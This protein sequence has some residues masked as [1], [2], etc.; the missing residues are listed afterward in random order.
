MFDWLIWR[1]A[2]N[3][4]RAAQ[5]NEIDR[6]REY[7]AKGADVNAKD[8]IGVTPLFYTANDGSVEAARLLLK[9]GADILHTVP[10]GGTV[11]HSALLK[12]HEDL[13]LFFIDQGANVNQATVAGV[14]PL[15]MAAQSGL[16][17]V[18]ARLL[19]RSS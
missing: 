7:I 4:H 15:H 3:L 16:R 14:T 8:R 11:L 12:E 2:G 17:A 19:N 1:L 5:L 6:M 9:H 10:G 13:A 18:V